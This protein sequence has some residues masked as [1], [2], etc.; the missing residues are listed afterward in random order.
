M[1]VS[2]KSFYFVILQEKIEE[3]SLRNHCSRYQNEKKKEEER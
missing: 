2:F 3:I 1:E